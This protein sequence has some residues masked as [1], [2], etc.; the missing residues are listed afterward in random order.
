MKDTF[1]KYIDNLEK[2]ST[3]LKKEKFI[4]DD[5]YDKDIKKT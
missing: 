3:D 1:S 4:K 5:K 2:V